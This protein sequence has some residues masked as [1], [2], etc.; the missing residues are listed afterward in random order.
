MF[1][2]RS[3]T[4]GSAAM[5]EIQVNKIGKKATVWTMLVTFA[6]PKFPT[7]LKVRVLPKY[8]SLHHKCSQVMF[9]LTNYLTGKFKTLSLATCQ[10]HANHTHFKVISSKYNFFFDSGPYGTHVADVQQPVN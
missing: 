4:S 3:D 2:D 9:F 8:Y 7:C 10:L 6:K 5:H 1:R